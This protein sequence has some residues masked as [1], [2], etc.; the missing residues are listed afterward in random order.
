MRWSSCSGGRSCLPDSSVAPPEVK[1]RPPGGQRG[2]LELSFAAG[3]DNAT[4]LRHQFASYP[5]HLC[6]PF[7]LPGDPEGMATLYIQSCSG[8]IYEGDRLAV[9]ID[10]QDSAK[11][12]VTSQAATIAYG[13]RDAGAEQHA[14]L[15]AGP[16]SMAEYLPDP[17][18]LFP[19]ARVESSLSVQWDPTARVVAVE[20]FL[21]HDPQ[22]RGRPFSRL[23]SRFQVRAAES[24][25]MLFRDRLDIPGDCW[26]R[27]RPGTT[28]AAVGLATLVFLGS[29]GAALPA[30]LGPAL[31][32][33]PGLWAGASLLPNRIGAICRMLAAD[34]HALRRGIEAGWSAARVEW[35]GMAPPRRR[36]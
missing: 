11:A 34:G 35:T 15:S 13:M 19:R 27:R 22:G 14:V 23:C 7:L 2:R 26:T 16:G 21:L 5:F 10:L 30:R 31:D 36:K 20:A 8:G 17:M 3:M 24:G 29:E 28:G 6:R 12:H 18:I 1:A 4:Q 32:D 33:I 9:E 25:S